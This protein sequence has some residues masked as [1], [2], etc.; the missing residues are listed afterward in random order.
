MPCPCM[1]RCDP[2]SAKAKSIDNLSDAEQAGLLQELTD[3]S[4]T[5]RLASRQIVSSDKQLAGG[6]TLPD[7]LV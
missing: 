7:R 2:S 4:D 6:I 5:R 1:G 3:E